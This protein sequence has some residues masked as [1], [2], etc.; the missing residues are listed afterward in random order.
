MTT[1]KTVAVTI[2]TF[3]GK[4]NGVGMEAGA[5][6]FPWAGSWQSGPRAARA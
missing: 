2:Q 4:G 6:G 5:G 3:V 1:G